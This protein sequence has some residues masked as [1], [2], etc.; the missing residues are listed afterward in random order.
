[1]IWFNS[2]ADIDEPFRGTINMKIVEN[3]S[4]TVSYHKEL[5]LEVL[6]LRTTV[7]LTMKTTYPTS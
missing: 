4:I 5:M 1:M 2:S 7:H 6:L 3:V